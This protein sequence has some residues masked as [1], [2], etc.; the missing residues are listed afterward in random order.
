MSDIGKHVL[1]AVGGIASA[2][3]VL[4]VWESAM[5]SKIPP[6]DM[7][8]YTEG[9]KVIPDEICV[10]L[11]SGNATAAAVG[12]FTVC[13]YVCMPSARLPC[14]CVCVDLS[15][16]K[17]KTSNLAIYPV[18]DR[19]RLYVNVLNTR[20]ELCARYTQVVAFRSTSPCHCLRFNNDCT[21]SG[22]LYTRKSPQV[23]TSLDGQR[24]HM[25]M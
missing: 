24:L 5:S 4:A 11:L 1:V 21:A 9:Q 10:A 17:E 3:V 12:A 22:K 6:E 7:S 20:K 13:K 14:P 15:L 23:C 25:Q 18:L 19:E 8:A 16:I 2:F